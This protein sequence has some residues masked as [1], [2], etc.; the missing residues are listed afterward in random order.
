ME[1]VDLSV[2]AAAAGGEQAGLPGRE[3][4]GFYRRRMG[5]G[6]CLQAGGWVRKGER[7]SGGGAG[8]W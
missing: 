4:E 3:R 7:A 6:V 1:E 2:V 5:E 8:R